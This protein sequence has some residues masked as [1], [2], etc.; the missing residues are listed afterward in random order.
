MHVVTAIA[1]LNCCVSMGL[2]TATALYGLWHYSDNLQLVI[3]LLA[4]VK[5]VSAILFLFWPYIQWKLE[6]SFPGRDLC[7]CSEKDEI[8]ILSRLNSPPT[9]D[10][11]VVVPAFNEEERLPIMLKETVSYLKSRKDLSWEIIVVNDGSKDR[12]TEVALQ[13][14]QVQAL[15]LARNNGK[16]GAVR[17]GVLASRGKSILMVD[18]DGATRFA[19]YANLEKASLNF[20]VVFGSRHHLQESE[21]VA[22]RNVL[23]NVLMHAFHFLVSLIVGTSVKDTQCGF[24]L[25]SREAARKLFPGL[26]LRRWAFDIE[27]VVLCRILNLEISEV[28]VNWM[29]IAGSKLNII[30]GSIQM[31]RDMTAVRLFYFLGL[32]TARSKLD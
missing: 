1:F 17:I 8:S 26:H 7:N 14:P 9:C 15:T 3:I 28:P 29:E 13:F 12:T 30:S 4:I 23:R 32:W 21:A 16:G 31:L 25:F 22:K 11:S 2:I 10:L 27:L 19:D 18:A 5:I 20:Q 24:K 6:K